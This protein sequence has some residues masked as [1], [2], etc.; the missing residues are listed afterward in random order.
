MIWVT[1]HLT[2]EVGREWG[3]LRREDWKE[4]A[5]EVVED[6]EKMLRDPDRKKKSF[7]GGSDHLC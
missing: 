5:A 3:W 2:T 4:M 6:Q 1:K 7:L